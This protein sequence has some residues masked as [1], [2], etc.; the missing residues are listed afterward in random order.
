MARAE[1]EEIPGLLDLHRE[2]LATYGAR[3]AVG[4]A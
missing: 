1:R 4:V 2:I 3:E